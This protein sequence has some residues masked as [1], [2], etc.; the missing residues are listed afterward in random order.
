MLTSKHKHTRAALASQQHHHSHSLHALVAVTRRH[1][2]AVQCPPS[3]PTDRQGVAGGAPHEAS[4]WGGLDTDRQQPVHPDMADGHHHQVGGRR[5]RLK[6]GVCAVVCVAVSA[7]SVCSSARLLAHVALILV[8]A[9]TDVAKCCLPGNKS[10][11]TVERLPHCLP[12]TQVG[13]VKGPLRD[14]WGLTTDGQLLIAT[15]SSATLYFIDPHTLQVCVV[16]IRVVHTSCLALMLESV[17][18]LTV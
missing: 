10:R 12:N 13:E 18:A 9:I 14:G 6:N 16:C 2:W 11:P 3:G 17:D 5:G 1:V 4:V 15:D 8:S 7:S